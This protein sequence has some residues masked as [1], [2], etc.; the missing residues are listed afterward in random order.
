VP[1]RNGRVSHESLPAGRQHGDVLDEV[2]AA[3]AD[4]SRIVVVQHAPSVS[5]SL[6]EAFGL[7]P[8]TDVDGPLV[9]ALRRL[10][11]HAVFDTAFSADLT[12]VEEA[13]ELVGRLTG[14]GPL[15]MMTSCSPGWIMFVEQFYPEFIP[16][17]STCKSPQQ[18]LGAIV[19]TC[20][21][22]RLHVDPARQYSVA[23]M[24]C[25]AP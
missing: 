25:T 12:V 5:V 18:M 11:F 9:T 13:S 15:P 1:R 22:E 3:L 8:G 6:A 21:A 14:G 23:V 16:N 7:P 24:P 20:F 4:P 17:L 2:R 19:K 10:G